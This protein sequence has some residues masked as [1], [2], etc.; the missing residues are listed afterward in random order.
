MSS[1]R[2]VRARGCDSWRTMK[3][4]EHHQGP[5]GGWD[6]DLKATVGTPGD[7]VQG[8]TLRLVFLQSEMESRLEWGTGRQGD[9]QEEVLLFR[10]EWGHLIVSSWVGEME[11]KEGLP[12][13]ELVHCPGPRPWLWQ[14]VRSHL[15][16]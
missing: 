3:Q 2:T 15:L 6:L 11:D 7:A 16:K 1:R 9:W 13:P 14:G 12:G 4:R 8:G 5:A 10:T